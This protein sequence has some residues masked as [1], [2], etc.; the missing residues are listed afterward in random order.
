LAKFIFWAACILK[1]YGRWQLWVAYWT[2]EHH[3]LSLSSRP[4]HSAGIGCRFL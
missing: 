2:V 1:G 3:H 4:T